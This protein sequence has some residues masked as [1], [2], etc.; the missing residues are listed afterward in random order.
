MLVEDGHRV[1][2]EA[3]LSFPVLQRLL[4]YRVTSLSACLV[5]HEHQDHA[6]SVR[7]VLKA[8]VPVYATAGTIDALELPRHHRLRRVKLLEPFTIAGFSV[9]A[10]PAIHDAAEPCGFMIRGRKVKVAYL[11]DTAFSEYR[12]D[13]CTHVLIEANYSIE[14]LQRRLGSLELD[15]SQFQRIVQ[16]HMSL[17]RAIELLRASDLSRCEEVWLLH[18]SAGNSD[19]AAFRDA[20]QR[21]TGVPTYVAERMTYAD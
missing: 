4:R 18:L 1:L 9:V 12:V 19:A 11:T 10:F 21:A 14:I 6:R 2:I 20:V 15:A 13:G 3:G 7:Q 17:E 5:S 16:N 8:G